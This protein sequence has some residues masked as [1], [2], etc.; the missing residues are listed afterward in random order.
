MKHLRAAAAVMASGALLFTG[1]VTSA[2][3][4]P[5]GAYHHPK[6]APLKA[7]AN[8]DHLLFGTAVNMD[9]LAED[10]TYRKI[11]AREFSSV[12]AENVMKWE[13]LQP[14]RGVY[15]FT[16]GDALVKFARSNG[17]AV[18]GHTLLWHN[19]L[20]GWL[21]S[22]VADGSIS[23]D[24]LRQILREHITTVA[25]HYKGKLYQWDVVN[26]VFEEDGSYRQSLW[27]QQLGPS[28]IA[29]AFRWAHQADPFAKLYVNDYNVEGVNAKS[30]AYY[31]LVKDLRAQ[32]VKV[33][34]FGI[35]GHL[36]TRYGFPGDI[37][38]N[39]KRFADI[40][41]ESSFTEVDVRG[42]MP[43]DEAKLDRQ[44]EYFGRMLDA[45]LDQ[46][47]CTSFTIWGFADQYSW[48][49]GVFDGEGSANIY[50][51][52]YAPKPSYW[53]VRE[54]LAGGRND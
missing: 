34:G 24:E 41:V 16:Q 9:A 30:T 10:T 25:K 23:K 51:E 20:P 38:A 3:A 50:D 49:P 17:Q 18:R 43:M 47:K 19:Q 4:A 37:P 5:A 54:E 40:G 26:E 31:N 32:G 22:G 27:Y 11:T 36:S 6:G 45:C 21:T 52:N 8:R 39:L 28:Y 53:A 44:A 42:D 1:A 13:T 7:L 15:D 35:Q 29:D 46:R 14:Q 33:D 48:V 12:T 2:Q